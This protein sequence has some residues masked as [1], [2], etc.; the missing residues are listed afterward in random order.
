MFLRCDYID[1][2]CNMYVCGN[3]RQNQCA[4]YVTH[5][6]YQNIAMSKEANTCQ[7]YARRSYLVKN[8]MDQAKATDIDIHVIL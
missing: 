5:K 1:Q 6:S 2:T 4:S 8:Q 7:L 3:V